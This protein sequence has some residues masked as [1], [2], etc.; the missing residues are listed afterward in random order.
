MSTQPPGIEQK[1]IFITLTGRLWVLRLSRSNFIIRAGGQRPY[2]LA[3]HTPQVVASG[4]VTSPDD[5][6]RYIQCT[7]LHA[8]NRESYQRTVAGE[9]VESL[10]WLSR[11]GFLLYDEPSRS[12][13]PTPLGT[14][15]FVSGGSPDLASRVRASLERARQGL[16]MSSD[17]HLTF[18][19]TPVDAA[20]QQMD[21]RHYQLMFDQL[22]EP[23]RRVAAAVGVSQGFLVGMLRGSRP[24]N[25]DA[26]A[27]A[28]RFFAA[29]V[30]HDVVQ[31]RT[32]MRMRGVGACV[33][34][35]VRVC[36]SEE[37]GGLVGE[38][39]R[40]QVYAHWTRRLALLATCAAE[41]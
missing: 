6:Q 24:K 12:W 35:C 36:V 38:C 13:R 21:W 19:A 22:K 31:V 20:V 40:P 8:L 30:L 18:L 10:R 33:W 27:T 16:V 29:L 28:K 17:L 34:M 4:A 26:E 11:E 2:P 32:R 39:C 15:T 41:D 7:M 3:P 37:R 5:V 9:T 1:I 25:A 14:A 23:E